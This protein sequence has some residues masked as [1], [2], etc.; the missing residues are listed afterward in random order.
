MAIASL[1]KETLA[2]SPGAAT[3]RRTAA[4][5]LNKSASTRRTALRHVCAAKAAARTGVQQNA[6]TA[7]PT[8]GLLSDS[9]LQAD[10]ALPAALAAIAALSWYLW[11]QSKAGKQRFRGGAPS[12]EAV[13][14]DVS[15]PHF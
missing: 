3:P 5:R 14:Q 13:L 9:P 15:F 7:A 2:L 1:M 4:S 6:S 11:R 10:R 8:P 12:Y